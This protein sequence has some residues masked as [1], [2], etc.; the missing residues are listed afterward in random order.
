MDLPDTIGN[1]TVLDHTSQI[2]GYG[3]L[4]TAVQ[5]VLSTNEGQIHTK[6]HYFI[7]EKIIFLLLLRG[8]GGVLYMNVYYSECTQH[9]CLALEQNVAHKLHEVR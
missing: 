5:K 9:A 7:F 3:I 1:I 2:A 6:I 8:N 4:R